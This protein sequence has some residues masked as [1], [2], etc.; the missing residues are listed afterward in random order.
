M[1]YGCAIRMKFEL[2][3]DVFCLVTYHIP[4]LRH[5]ERMYV[6]TEDDSILGQRSNVELMQLESQSNDGYLM[7]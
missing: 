5:C 7:R 1:R 6:E 4:K 3:N 2:Y